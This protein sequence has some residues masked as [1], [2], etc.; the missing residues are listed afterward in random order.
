MIDSARICAFLQVTDRAKAKEFYVDVLGLAF[1]SEDPFALV[2]DSN[3]I[4]IRIGEVPDLKPAQVTVLG[5]DVANIEDAFAD[6]SAKGIEFQKYGFPGQDERGIWTTPNGDKVA[7]FK[8]PS[9]N[10]LSIAQHA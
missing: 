10:V 7:W 1:V 9:G 8:D 6:L 2:V 5:W 4:R 3:G